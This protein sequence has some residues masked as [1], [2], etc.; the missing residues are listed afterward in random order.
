MKRQGWLFVALW[1][2]SIAVL[3]AEDGG[4]LHS[5]RQ[6]AAR[7]KS[8]DSYVE[9]CKY[10]YQTEEDADL[11]L[12]YADSIH[13]LAVGSGMPEQLVEY[14]VWQVK[15]ISSRESLSKDMR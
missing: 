15:G 10:L 8:L 7:N 14:Y 13:Q 6:H 4:D 9:V 2:F 12:L 5:L 3:W 11:L 1:F